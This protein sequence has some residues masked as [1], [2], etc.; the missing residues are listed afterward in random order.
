MSNS[1]KS[2]IVLKI[3]QSCWHKKTMAVNEN[4]NEFGVEMIEEEDEFED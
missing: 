3:K 4:V 2:E 1:N